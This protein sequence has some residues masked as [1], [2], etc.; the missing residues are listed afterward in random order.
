MQMKP[1][2]VIALASVV[3]VPFTYADSGKGKGG[4][5]VGGTPG[6]ANGDVRLIAKMTPVNSQ[7][8]LFEGH[9]VRRTR[10]TAREEFEARAEVPLDLLGTVDPADINPD[11]MLAA[12]TIHCTM[13][14]DQVD[15]ITGVAQYKTSIRSRNG[16][17]VNRAGSCGSPGAPTIPDVQAGHSASVAIGD[18][19]LLGTFVTK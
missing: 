1:M 7:N 8:S 3:L 12:N 17:V 14:L 9:A 2:M 15:A 18:N 6:L 5:G 10:G 13:V 4:S 19:M 11:L 16:N